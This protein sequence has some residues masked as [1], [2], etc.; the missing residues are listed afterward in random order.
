[1]RQ[2]VQQ[3]G[4]RKRH[5]R[6]LVLP[7]F[8]LVHRRWKMCA[9]DKVK[10]LL[11]LVFVYEP[12]VLALALCGKEHVKVEFVE[13]SLHGYLPYLLGYLVGHENHSR[14]RKIRIACALPFSFCPLFVGIRPVEYLLLDELAAVYCTE[15]RSRKIKIVSRCY[16]QECFVAGVSRFLL[17]IFLN[18][19]IRL[20]FFVGI[21][22]Q[23]S[24]IFTP[25]TEMILVKDN[26][27][28]V[29]GMDKL[30]LRLYTAVFVSPEQV[31]ERTENN[32]RFRLVGISVRAVD[33]D[34]VVV[35]VLV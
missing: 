21:I 20:G 18:V 9:A 29:V 26:D 5:G 28:P 30:V 32:Y 2:H 31:L 19:K 8:K 11:H 27:I 12:C 33:V 25:C 34:F 24:R 17:L 14:K 22:E 3:S 13:L 10:P 16:G 35:S 1:M 7:E 23:L 6:A 15:R 4:I